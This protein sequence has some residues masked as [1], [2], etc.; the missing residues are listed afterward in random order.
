MD[1]D[2]AR[3]LADL[4]GVLDG[5]I[6]CDDLFLQIYASD[7]SLYEIKPLAVVRPESLSDVVSVVKY[8]AENQLSVIPRG[9]GSNVIGASLGNGIVLDFSVGMR[10]ILGVDRESVRVQP[11]VAIRD[12]N[13]NLESHQQMFSPDPATRSV[14]T[15]G[16]ALAMNRTGSHWIASG[17]PRDKVVQLQMVMADGEVVQLDSV[18]NQVWV[19]SASQPAGS[20]ARIREL[21]SRVGNV[22]RSNEK[23]IADSIPDTKVN[24]AGYHLDSVMQS[25]DVDLTRLAIGSEG[26][27][28]IITEAV[29]RTDRL[30]THRGVA[31]LFFHQLQAAATAAVDIGKM[32]ITACDLMD[33]RLLTLARETNEQFQ[34]LLPVDAEA[35]LL[36][37]F[38]A[39]DN[40][41][42]RDKLQHLT[43]R[44]QRRK[45]LAFEVRTT[46]QPAERNL[47]WHLVRRVVPSL[48]R[49]RGLRRAVPFIEDIAIA[50]DRLPEFLKR[51]HGVLNEHDITASIFSHTPQ[52]MVHIR[53][54]LNLADPKDIARMK[55]VAK[56]VFG[57]TLEMN[58]S[59][60]GS[61]GDGLGRTWFLRSQYGKLHPVFSEIK[62]IFDPQNVLNPGKIVGLPYS[63][64]TDNLRIFQAEEPIVKTDSDAETSEDEAEEPTPRKLLTPFGRGKSKS[65]DG[66]GALPV[67][68]PQL[69]WSVTQM[70]L[71]AR[72]CNGCARCR[73][74]MHT[75]R[76][77][78]VY[79]ASPREES[80][81]R[82]KANLIRGVVSGALSP[83]QMAKDEFKE[84]AD[85]CFNCHQCRLECPASVDIP[86]LMVEAK[87]QYY[88]TNGLRV[89]DWILTR[90]DW[91]YGLGGRAPRLTNRMIRSPM[92]RWILDRVFGI[93]QG[94][95]LPRFSTRTF[96]RWAQKNQLGRPSR[97]QSRKVVYFYDAWVNWN[98]PELGRSFVEVLKHNNID[99]LVPPN[100]GISG[101]SMISDGAIGR[102]Q[103]IAERNVEM[104]AEWVR[105]G[106]RIVTT[107][108][109]AALALKH[110][111]LNLLD[112]E[113]A[114]KV[115]ENTTDCC[116]F[117]MELHRSG[118]LALDFNPLSAL[119]GYHL[120]CHQ[121]AIL[122]SGLVSD[123][124]AVKLM[125][126]IPGMQVE[127]LDKG[128]SGMAG[129]YG[130]KRRNY[131]RSLRIGVHLIQ[132]MRQPQLLAGSTECSSCKIQMEQGTYKTTV[133][134]V[135]ILALAYGLMPSELEDLFNRRS[136]EL[137]VT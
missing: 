71:A 37:E 30:P 68:Q 92:W 17:T 102:A 16:G 52:G 24:Q 14:T 13:R 9:S 27:L 114:T 108:P 78:P 44:I 100:Q 126:L 118:E 60:S 76:M 1:P 106:Y 130:L 119:V 35:M 31:L 135:K 6:R 3:I 134:P 42:L 29:V 62:N 79:R 98:D 65:G 87:G 83:D 111:Y 88:A 49:L 75:E 90:L 45:K 121:R 5:Q 26:T 33:R 38:S 4:S 103:A 18:A 82:A 89:S 116:S 123:I 40:A 12:L 117:L 56:A 48:Y 104:L 69:D 63:D 70:G 61:Q 85:L 55:P 93:A 20:A 94:R 54:F 110:E 57:L 128:C 127:V 46:T 72:N 136:E 122:K 8:A 34:R 109:S 43:N 10:Q 99:V 7:A 15:I 21:K 53:P 67:L 32:G 80:S 113:D 22:I 59:I 73:T 41:T 137:V 19:N 74:N 84:I 129:T 39:D 131:R 66:D 95:K 101:M 81:P 115:A 51:V 36:V 97:Q 11:G 25:D 132:A 105:Q 77:C 124:P 133:H 96:A 50:P 120:P 28:G 64:L 86:K 58:G 112:D 47:Y 23:L 91:L 125:Q 2:R 107:E